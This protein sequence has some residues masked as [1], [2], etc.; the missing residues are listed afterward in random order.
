VA[1]SGLLHG[2]KYFY[3][4]HNSMNDIEDQT[5][6]ESTLELYAQESSLVAFSVHCS[7]INHES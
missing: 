7:M 2:K 3:S 6:K 4:F 1:A 5:S